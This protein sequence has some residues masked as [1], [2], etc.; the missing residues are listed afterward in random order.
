MPLRIAAA[1][2]LAGS[3]ARARSKLSITGSRLFIKPLL[4]NCTRWSASASRRLRV[5]WKSAVARA[6][7]SNIESRSA[8]SNATSSD[9]AGPPPAP[10]APPP[11]ASPPPL[12]AP[13]NVASSRLSSSMGIRVM[14]P[15]W[16]FVDLEHLFQLV[17]EAPLLRHRAAVFGGGE[18]AQQVLLLFRQLLGDL[19]QDLDQ[20]VAA[21]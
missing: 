20:L 10:P 11:A 12:P 7:R 21:A 6:R 13:W 17:H 19:D 4:A 14:A 9:E 8:R 3:I 18:V 2:T 15:P 16:S 1:S 5:F